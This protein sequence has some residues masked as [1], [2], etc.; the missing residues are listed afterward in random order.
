MTRV[1]MTPDAVP[2][3]GAERNPL[4]LPGPPSS[5]RFWLGR[6]WA[7]FRSAW[8]V[9]LQYR[10]AI[11]IWL[12]LGLAQPLVMLAIWWS[13]AG[14]GGVGGIGRDGFA[15]YFFAL[16]LVDQLTLAWDVWYVDRW[17]RE[18][19][20]NYR[21]VRPIN[22]L[23]EAISDNAAYKAGSAS[24]LVL[25]WLGVAA[26]W[27]AVR[28][29]VQPVRWLGALLA[30]VLAGGIRFLVS[31]VHGLLAFW[32]TRASGIFELHYGISL[33]LAGRIA[34]LALLPPLAARAAS[35]L[36]F[37]SMLAFP[38]EVLT[39]SVATLRDYGAGVG[40][41]VFWL[42]AWVLA[43]RIAWS[44]GLDRYEGVGG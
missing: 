25:V 1:V 17:I 16:M 24:L 22:P 2:P 42:I 15:Q 35:I 8:L 19:E 33:F 12:V 43:Y 34:P 13:V 41:Q 44:R 37:R 5:R 39:G 7:L 28:I 30:V 23:H 18:G 36:W 20:L 26:L 11:L 3:G 27:P 40:A 9:D 32:T 29:P 21:L 38:V 6:Y 4:G 31:Y 14:S 10:P